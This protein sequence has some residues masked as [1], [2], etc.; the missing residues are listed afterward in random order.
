MGKRCYHR[1]SHVGRDFRMSLVQPPHQIR[2]ETHPD[3]VSQGFLQLRLKNLQGQRFHNVSRKLSPMLDCPWWFFVSFCQVRTSP[4][5]GNNHC[6]I[7]SPCTSVQ[8]LHIKEYKHALAINVLCFGTCSYIRYWSEDKLA[9]VT[10][11]S[12]HDCRCKWDCYSGIT[13][14][15][16][17]SCWNAH[18]SSDQS[19]LADFEIW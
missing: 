2:V 16:Q 13:I 9:A 17:F 19:Q 4:T 8:Y 18:T 6:H 14:T 3:Q 5:P 15:P 12:E 10:N 1:V 7:N 11:H